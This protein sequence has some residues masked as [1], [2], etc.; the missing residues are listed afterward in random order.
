MADFTLPYER[1]EVLR[2]RPVIVSEFEDLTQQRREI[3]D[4]DIAGF[5][6]TT[7]L[8]NE[9]KAAEYLSHWNTQRGPLLSFGFT[10]RGTAHTVVYEGEHRETY[11]RGLIRYTFRF[12]KVNS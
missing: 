7:P 12:T 11:E 2:S 3:S 10:Y 5:H 1:C 8:L 9:A 6:I 4:K